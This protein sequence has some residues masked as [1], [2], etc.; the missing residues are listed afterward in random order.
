[1]G[2]HRQRLVIMEVVAC[3]VTHDRRGSG[4]T[5][6]PD[7]GGPPVFIAVDD[8]QSVVNCQG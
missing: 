2:W 3:P 7:A 8:S 6:S 5:M 1:M 4:I